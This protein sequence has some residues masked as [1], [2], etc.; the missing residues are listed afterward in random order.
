M[1]PEAFSYALYLNLK[2][3]AFQW[4]V[5]SGAYMLKPCRIATREHGCDVPSVSI[6]WDFDD[7]TE[8]EP[9]VLVLDNNVVP[10]DAEDAA[11]LTPLLNNLAAR[12]QRELKERLERRNIYNMKKFADAI[13]PGYGK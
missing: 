10:I 1:L 7:P 2:E 6:A 5:E 8:A 11:A 12:H 9:F 3:C 4:K 13:V